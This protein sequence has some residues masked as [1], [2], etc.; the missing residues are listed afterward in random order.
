MKPEDVPSL[1][2]V[3][4]QIRAKGAFDPWESPPLLGDKWRGRMGFN[5]EDQLKLAGQLDTPKET[6]PGEVSL[7]PHP[8]RS[9]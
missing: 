4:M 6:S 1:L 9:S 5:K 7:N 2:E 3:L 8:S